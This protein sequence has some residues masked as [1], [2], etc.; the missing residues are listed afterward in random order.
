MFNVGCVIYCPDKYVSVIAFPFQH[1][2]ILANGITHAID[3]RT[4]DYVQAVKK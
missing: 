1:E 4:M 2:T 3:Y